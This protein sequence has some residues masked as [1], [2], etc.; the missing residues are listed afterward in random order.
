MLEEKRE[1]LKVIINSQ[2]LSNYFG[3]ERTPRE[4]K[5]I[6]LDLLDDWKSKQPPEKNVPVI[7]QEKDR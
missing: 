2:E 7:K 3:P 1:E 4:M 5:N 6:I